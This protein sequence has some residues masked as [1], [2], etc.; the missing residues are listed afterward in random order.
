MRWER[1]AYLDHLAFRGSGR[2]MAVELFGPLLG[3]AEKWRDQGASPE[4]IALTAFAWD[5]IEQVALPMDAGPRSG[6]EEAVLREDEQQKVVRDRFGRVTVLPKKF[7]TL[8]LPQDFPLSG[9]DDWDR[10]RGWFRFEED[11]LDPGALEACRR[12]R[13]EGALVRAHVWGAYDILRQL[14]GDEEACLA[15][16]EEP[17]LVA[18]IL[19]TVG[20]LQ[21]RLLEKALSVC[22]VD[23]LFVHEDF[24]GKSGP[25]VGPG[26]VRQLFNPYYR[27][28]WDVARSGGASIFDLDTDGDAMPVVDALLEG[29][30]NCLHPVEPAGKMD[31]VA[32]RRR[33]GKRLALR[34]GID[35]FALG[36]GPAAIEAELDYRID[37]GL[38]GGG[39]VFG[40]DHRIPDDVSI[41]AYRYY[42]GRLREKLG[43]PPVAADQPGWARMA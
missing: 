6:L 43:L 11:R 9:P 15:V 18:D 2:E 23:M 12:Q 3:T 42:V 4:E 27:P 16:L 1:E 17:D 28:L 38:L 41:E 26:I 19:Q 34:G 10:L 37:S 29:G 20:G 14:M 39:T 7:A 36:R 31:A 21:V 30:I 40:L 13:E 24:A 8:A 5:H 32:L 22:P 35:K 33:Y 25:L